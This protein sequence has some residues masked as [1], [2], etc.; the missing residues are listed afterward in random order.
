M[1]V[2]GPPDVLGQ[3]RDDGIVSAA[4]LGSPDSRWSVNRAVDRSPHRLSEAGRTRRGRAV[5][6]FGRVEFAADDV[7]GDLDQAQVAA[8]HVAAALRVSRATVY[9]LVHSGA[10]R[11]RRIGKSVRVIRRGVDQFLHRAATGGG[12]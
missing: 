7:A 4:T 12:P 8:S 6:E 5:A 1:S 3:E 9:R 10:L 2:S 11:G